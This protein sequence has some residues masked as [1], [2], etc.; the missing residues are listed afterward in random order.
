MEDSEWWL[1]YDAAAEWCAR[2]GLRGEPGD[3]LPEMLS[4]RCKREIDEHP[5][6]FQTRVRDT[7]YALAAARSERS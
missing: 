7:A 4:A 1:E 5:L 6:A 2:K 3:P